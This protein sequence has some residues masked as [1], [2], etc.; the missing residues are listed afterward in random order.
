VVGIATGIV[1]NAI[2]VNWELATLIEIVVCIGVFMSS[3][4][5]LSKDRAY[6]EKV[7]AFFKTLSTPA[8]K[9]KETGDSVMSGL[10]F[11]YAVAFSVTGLLFVAMGIPSADN[12]SGKLAIAAGIV[13]LIGAVVFYSKRKR[14]SDGVVSIGPIQPSIQ[15]KEL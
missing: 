11:L 10:M 13:C 5:F 1:L 15:L 8:S 9:I 3:G 7:A 14:K 4:F 2:G 12:M 6:N